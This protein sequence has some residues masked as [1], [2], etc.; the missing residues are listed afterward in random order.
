MPKIRQ[1]DLLEGLG[2]V[3]TWY[4]GPTNPWSGL[5]VHDWRRTGDYLGYENFGPNQR[6]LDMIKHLGPIM[7][8]R[9]FPPEMRVKAGMER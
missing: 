9:R 8:R 5:D 2:P 6:Q 1:Q 3:P 7:E 4:P